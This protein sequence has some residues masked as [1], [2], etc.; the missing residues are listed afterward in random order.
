MDSKMNQ[1]KKRLSIINLAISITDIETIQLQILKLALIK[2]DE[3]I[4]KIIS[5]LQAENYAQAQGLISTYIE[6][7]MDEILQRTSQKSS[8]NISE[9]DQALIDEFQLFVS[10]PDAKTTQ[11]PAELD[12]NNYTS[13]RPQY[14]KPKHT[15][16]FD[17]L[18][19]LDPDD[20]LPDNIDIDIST[21]TQKDTFFTKEESEIK[22]VIPTEN[23][24]KDT[25][26]DTEETKNVET[27]PEE[28]SEYD[29]IL[30]LSTD[31]ESNSIISE[32]TSTE[33]PLKEIESTVTQIPSHYPAMPH[34]SQKF[35]RMKKEYPPIQKSYEKFDTVENLL[36]KIS[37]KGYT[38]V[39]MEEMTTFIKK[40]TQTSKFTE[41]S[42]LLL[43]CGA[44]ESKF[45]QFMF[46]R[47][48]FTGSLLTKN[49]NES[50]TL[51]NALATDD[52]P[53]ALCDLAQF[54]E[55]GIGTDK[56]TMKAESL[57]KEALNLG[58]KRA[59]KHYDRLKKQ[60]RRL[61]KK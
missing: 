6:T 46:A 59:S 36:T 27:S 48:L 7:P 24:P 35:I 10:S 4:Q 19:S 60:N 31:E 45:A 1:T 57:Y 55:H 21:P 25:F 54:Y 26:F 18:L 44:T 2:T 32:E 16:D 12:I 56:D 51:M 43:L 13:Q 30:A 49:I 20:V 9:A 53:E 47:A 8:T 42:Q 5:V 23:I 14:I 39:E 38:E 58:I 41:A 50:F 40:L 28:E 17:S 29:N 52:Y 33:T 61:F 15:I 3:K 11:Q 34:I 22:E 37:Q